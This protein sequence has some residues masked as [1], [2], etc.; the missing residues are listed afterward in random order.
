MVFSVTTRAGVVRT[1]VGVAF[2]ASGAALLGTI[3]LGF[4][5]PLGLLLTLIAAAV[6]A[7]LALRSID[8][9]TRQRIDAC[10]QAGAV[11][12]VLGLIC[13]DSSKTILSFADPSPFN[14]FG[15][16][17]T[18]GALLIGTDAPGWALQTAGIGFHIL[19]GIAFAIAYATL[20]ARFGATSRRRAV[21]QGMAW[22]VFLETFQLTLYPGWLDIKAYAEFATI[23]AGAHLIYGAVLGL[24]SRQLLRR[25]FPPLSDQVR[26]LMPEGG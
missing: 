7:T 13:Y 9:E 23:S 26:A 14:P 22:G 1:I 21:L 2:L 15:A 8:A 6:A 3:L 11:A 16:T 4:A 10:V 12:G 25:R 24:V 20:F 5:L 17:A 19:N 18:F